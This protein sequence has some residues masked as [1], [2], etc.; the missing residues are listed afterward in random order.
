MYCY[1]N[2][3]PS[4][5]LQAT[6]GIP[7]MCI[8]AKD[9]Q[10]AP[11]SCQFATGS[12]NGTVILWSISREAGG[13]SRIVSLKE[14]P[15]GINEELSDIAKNPRVQIQSLRFRDKAIVA[16]TRSGNILLISIEVP[17]EFRNKDPDIRDHFHRIFEPNDHDT[18]REAGFDKKNECL[19]C[20]SK[21]G[22]LSSWRY[23]SLER[24]ENLK[25]GVNSVRLLVCCHSPT[26]VCVFRNEVM[27]LDSSK[28][29]L[30]PLPV[31]RLKLLRDITDARINGEE[32][33]LALALAASSESKSEIQ[34]YKIDAL[35]GLSCLASIEGL[36]SAVEVM[37]FTADNV[38]LMFKE[39]LGQKVFFDLLNLRPNDLLGQ[40]FDPPFISTGLSLSPHLSHLGSHLKGEV[41]YT[42]VCRI[43]SRSIA[44]GDTC[45]MLRLF[46]FPATSAPGSKLYAHH[47]SR[48]ESVS[49]SHRQDLLV[50]TSSYDRSILIWKIE[51]ISKQFK[52][53]RILI[54]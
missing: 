24:K 12:Y 9:P 36:I 41:E 42:A 23:P 27:C 48:I 7:I 37:D 51:R 45:G 18:P 44:T 19:Y 5:K 39:T 16:G 22:E 47:L 38:Y 49:L 20:L 3:K 50:S 17:E 28:D 25:L 33:L 46:P 35:K 31:L 43:A 53:P 10:E 32:S 34:I 30:E 21:N 15:L 4:K 54:N 6:P 13:E 52:P 29:Y 8:T 40:S 14:F 1:E 26:V 11:F 2:L